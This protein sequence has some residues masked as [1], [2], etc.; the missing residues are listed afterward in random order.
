MENVKN[1]KNTTD[2]KKM[3][4][5]ITCLS[6]KGQNSVQRETFKVLPSCTVNSFA[7]V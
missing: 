3:A 2:E 4:L 7:E 5:A 6:H 1:F